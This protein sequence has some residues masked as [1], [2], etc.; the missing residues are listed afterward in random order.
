MLEEITPLNSAQLVHDILNP[1]LKVIQSSELQFEYLTQQLQQH[2]R[3]VHRSLNDFEN[4]V[5]DIKISN[6]KFIIFWDCW[7]INQNI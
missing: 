7:I 6:L 3:Y 1:I 4:T 2:Y 5:E